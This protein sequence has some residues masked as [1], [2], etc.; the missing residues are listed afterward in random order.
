MENYKNRWSREEIL[1][2]LVISGLTLAVYLPS[3]GH[4]FLFNWDDNLYVLKNAAVR[5]FTVENLRQ[6]FS[7]FYVGNY[8]PLHIISYMLDYELWGMRPAG[9]I[10]TN[11]LLHTLNALLFYRIV[12]F[13]HGERTAA[14]LAALVFALH[15]I[16]VESVVW[17]SQRKNVLAM[18]FFLLSFL[19]YLRWTH[20]SGRSWRQYAPALVFFTAA[21]LT[22]SV[23]VILPLLLLLYDATRPVVRRPGILLN[24]L[25]FLAI[26]ILSAV[27]ALASQAEDAGGGRTG[28]HGGSPF[29]TACTMLPVLFRYFALLFRPTNLSIVYDPP[30]RSGLDSTVLAALAGVI[31]LAMVA[32]WLWRRRKTTCFWFLAF[33]IALLP[34]AQIVPLVTLMNDRYLYFPMLGFAALAG[35]AGARMLHVLIERQAIAVA[36]ATLLVL[37]LAGMAY[38]RTTVWQNS[39]ALWHDA[40]YK[41]PHSASVWYGLGDV[42]LE[43]EKTGLARTAY[44]TALARGGSEPDLLANLAIVAAAEGRID[45]AFT[46]LKKAIELGYK[47]V[48]EMSSDRHLAAL[49][50]DR[51]FKLLLEQYFPGGK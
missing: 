32:W 31:A 7:G 22:K 30:V 17:V 1:S 49:R 21:L 28:Y 12:F 25:P 40:L 19:T 37:P 3:L 10:A 26:A 5:G 36:V 8:A 50:R 4:E 20:G 27:L 9:F 47:D 2:L 14:L 16:Q 51:R 39:F 38:Q 6:A 11:V 46:L 24:K 35:L 13:M 29:A 23:A 33:F 44:E 43:Q 48:E 41:S 15:P 18:C 34:V 45:D 42:Y